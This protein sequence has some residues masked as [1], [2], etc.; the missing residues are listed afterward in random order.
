MASIS[1]DPS[2]R[3]RILFKGLDGAR[4]TVRLGVC[5]Q[6]QA[7]EIR[8]GIESLLTAAE[9]G[10]GLD[11]QTTGWLEGLG[12]ALHE[13]L[14]QTG[15]CA[16]RTP[17]VAITLVEFL[18]GYIAGRNDLKRTTLLIMEQTRDR[19]T[20][21]LKSDR[22]VTG[23]SSADADGFKAHLIKEGLAKATVAKRIRYAR[24]FFEVAKRRRIIA[25]NPFAHLSGAV[26][27]N[28][29]RRVF[30]PASDVEKVIDVAPDS[31]WKLLIALARYGGLRIPS[32]AQALT[33]RDVDFAQ[34]RFIVRASKTEH[35]EDGGVRIVPMFP[36]LAKHFQAVFDEAEPGTKYVI[37]RYRGTT[38]N[39]R[40]QLLRYVERAGLKPWAKLWQNLRAS[41]ATELADHYPS[42]VCTAW[43][44]HTEKVADEFY[45]MVT[46][47]HFLK[48]TMQPNKATQ[49]PT[50]TGA[51]SGRK[52]VIQEKGGNQNTPENKLDA[53]SCEMVTAAGLGDGGLEPTT[54]SV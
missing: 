51:D 38:V 39:L 6:K 21:H 15:I 27:G 2:G 20:E 29:S 37:T 50:Q 32:E 4:K 30:V 49:N 31:Q 42:H 35:H 52:Q 44:G 34:S 23:V 5:S 7:D 47:S 25:E 54:S 18:N 43:L 26:K 3:R 8:G 14:A 33:W 19:L 17:A 41:R 16:S 28:P 10:R 13:R 9:C 1:T 45:R 36:E 53:K 48:A 40:T 22:L 46:D 11:R 12:D 24:H